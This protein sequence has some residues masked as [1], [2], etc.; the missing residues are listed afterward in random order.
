VINVQFAAISFYK[1]KDK[2]EA[3]TDT[4][5]NKIAGVSFTFTGVPMK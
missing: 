5:F 1:S 2:G 3:V 4:T